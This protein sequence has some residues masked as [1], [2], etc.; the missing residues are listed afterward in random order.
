MGFS[1]SEPS[2]AAVVGSLDA[3]CARYAAEVLLQGHR[4]EILQA[5]PRVRVAGPMLLHGHRAEI[6]QARLGVR[7]AGPMLARRLCT[8]SDPVWKAGGPLCNKAATSRAPCALAAWPPVT[9]EPAC[10]AYACLVAIGL[11]VPGQRTALEPGSLP[12]R[13]G[14]KDTVK[15]L[16]LAFYRAC[17]KRKPERLIFYRDGV[18]EGQARPLHAGVGAARPC[19]TLRVLCAWT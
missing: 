13:Q 6:L 9:H 17:D 8:Q 12:H 14:L 7:V 11:L 3:Y 5:R 4:V 1:E 19:L 10:P 2:I 16:L 18:S 15:K